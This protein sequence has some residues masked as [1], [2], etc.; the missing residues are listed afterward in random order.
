[1]YVVAEPSAVKVIVCEPAPAFT[2]V[3]VA[4][5]PEG[6]TAAD[7]PEITEV[8]LPPDGATVKVTETLLLSPVTEQLCVPVGGVALKTVQLKAPVD[9]FTTYVVATPLAV[10]DTT[11]EPLLA[12]AVG[13]ANVEVAVYV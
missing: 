5:A 9:A 6:V 4:S 8:S 10:N 3:G 11:A 1:M 7:G 12:T 13:A 2:T